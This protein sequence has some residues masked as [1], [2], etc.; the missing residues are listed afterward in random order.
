MAQDKGLMKVYSEL[1][2]WA[3]GIVVV[4]GL[5]VG[6]VAVNSIIKAIKGNA[7]QKK[8]EQ[9]VNTAQS[10]LQQQINKGVK[11]T[12]SDSSLQAMSSAIVEGAN[13]CDVSGSGA[14]SII[15]QFD[16]IQN[17][18]DILAF[19]KVFGLRKKVRCPFTS[20]TR[21]SFFSS[22]TPP[23]SLSAML[24]SELKQSQIDTINK[25]LSSK[26]IKYKF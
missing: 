21:E 26:G 9:E 18:A 5:V 22:S 23:L 8:Q 11:Q 16:K 17:E 15:A 25:K 19:V 3:K 14:N 1:P 6:Y 24:S 20:D 13:D 4:G 2:S 10:E 7:E 12:L